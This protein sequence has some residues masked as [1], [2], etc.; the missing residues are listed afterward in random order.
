MQD[1]GVRSMAS[2]VVAASS[3]VLMASTKRLLVAQHRGI[4]QKVHSNYVDLVVEFREKLRP[5]GS[6]GTVSLFPT[7]YEY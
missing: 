3:T 1:S 5:D 4:C 6:R 2:G 7:I